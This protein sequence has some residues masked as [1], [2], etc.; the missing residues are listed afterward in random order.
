MSD[1][2]AEILSNLQI[3]D[4]DILE[5]VHKELDLMEVTDAIGGKTNLELFHKIWCNNKL[6]FNTQK[7]VYNV[8]HKV[9]HKLFLWLN[10]E[11][12]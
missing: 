4:N 10:S 7:R 2:R 6:L 8:I 3:Q 9:L 1:L 12:I 5:H 11:L